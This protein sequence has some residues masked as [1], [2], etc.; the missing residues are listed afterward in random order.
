MPARCKRIVRSLRF[1]Q[2][3]PQKRIDEESQLVLANVMLDLAGQPCGRTVPRRTAGRANVFMKA[4][5]LASPD[6]GLVRGEIK[7]L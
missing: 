1:V 4:V 2:D 3:V 6:T 5:G 7:R